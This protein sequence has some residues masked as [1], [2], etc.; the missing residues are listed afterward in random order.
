MTSQL[1][2]N[3]GQM[4]VTAPSSGNENDHLDPELVRE[5]LA[6][7]IQSLE[8]RFGDRIQP[9]LLGKQK[10]L[11]DATT[12]ILLRT[13]NGRRIAVLLCSRPVA[14]DL[15]ARGTASAAAIRSVVGQELGS[16][17]IRPIA[18]GR[19]QGRSYEILPFCRDLSTHRWLR[20][21]QRTR[22]TRPLLQWLLRATEAAVEKHEGRTD[23]AKNFRTVL[24]YLYEQSLF[25]IELQSAM[26]RAID[27]I[28][29]R[30]WTPHH[31]FDHNDLYLSNIMLP[32]R[33]VPDH[34]AEWPFVLIDWAGANPVGFGMYD[35]V[36]LARAV[37]L[38]RRVFVEQL[39]R[40]ASA[41]RCTTNDLTGHFLAACGRLHQ[42]LE[43]FPEE[44]YVQTVEAC[45]DNLSSTLSGS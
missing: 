11:G 14:P 24:A 17:I 43:H 7:E 6:D 33:E 32:S 29:S 34:N 15:I 31:S 27:R 36:R 10:S 18:T 16:A 8:A 38:R 41:L 1:K 21:W 28:D 4:C 25:S 13:E 3:P 23:A 20:R 22:L 5:H 44:R 37:N 30:Q 39:Q 9:E 45:W 26:E 35:L 42:H 19:I 2:N 40:H 12:K